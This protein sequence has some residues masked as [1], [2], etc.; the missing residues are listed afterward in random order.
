MQQYRQVATSK[1]HLICSGYGLSLV[2]ALSLTTH[3]PIRH[4]VIPHKD[5]DV[6]DLQQRP[7]SRVCDV[8]L[9]ANTPTSS[10]TPC[11]Y[12]SKSPSPTVRA[13]LQKASH[14][15]RDCPRYLLFINSLEKQ[16]DDNDFPPLHSAG[17]QGC[18]ESLPW[19]VSW[20]QEG[21]WMKSS[22]GRGEG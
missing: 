19:L 17:E 18:E 2:G 15:S 14:V 1:E 16:R 3:F 10:I 22:Q 9:R 7:P 20:Q 12:A 21:H 13:Q 5:L 8:S 4:R 6:D 11:P